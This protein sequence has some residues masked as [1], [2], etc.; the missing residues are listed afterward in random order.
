MRIAFKKKIGLDEEVVGP[1][2]ERIYKEQGGQ[3]TPN[4]LVTSARAEDSPL[5]SY[6]EWDDSI[7]GEKYREWQARQLI[8]V[9]VLEGDN[10][11][12]FH[13]VTF[14]DEGGEKVR[15]YKKT[16]EVVQ[17]DALFREALGMLKKKVSTA[18]ESL[19]HLMKAHARG[20]REVLSRVSHH[21]ESANQELSQV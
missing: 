21:L 6:F 10:V 14:V 18:Q 19:N 8:R 15:A 2:L 1:E 12:A 13:N 20:D 7:A 9:V 4:A 17:D 3:L 11:P 16:T 5:H